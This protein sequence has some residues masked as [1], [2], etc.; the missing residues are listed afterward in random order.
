MKST[1]QRVFLGLIAIIVVPAL[2]RLPVWAGADQG[3][4]PMIAVSM[5]KPWG[6][7]V[8]RHEEEQAASLSRATAAE[9]GRSIA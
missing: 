2:I 3:V 8:S 5:L 7:H 6:K 4:I 9:A 1:R